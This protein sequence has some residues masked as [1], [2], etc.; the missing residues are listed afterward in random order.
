[1][2]LSSELSLGVVVGNWMINTEFTQK[3]IGRIYYQERNNYICMYNMTGNQNYLDRAAHYDNL[4]RE[5]YF[6]IIKD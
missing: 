1:M 3:G 4:M 6:N 2:S 5:T